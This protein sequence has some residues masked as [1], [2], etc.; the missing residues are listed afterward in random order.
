MKVHTVGELLHWSYANLAMAHAAVT[1]GSPR[2]G[3]RHFAIRSRL[4]AGLRNDSLQI[5]LLAEDERLKM[6]LPQACCYCGSTEKLAADHLIP[7]K[8]GGPDRGDNLVW[9]CRACNS[10]K[11]AS[12]ALEWYARRGEFPPLLVLRRYLKLALELCTASGVLQHPIASSPSLPVTL[13]AI[14]IS[15]PRPSE[16]RLWVAPIAS[17]PLTRS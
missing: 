6:V 1:D 15:F 14:P 5:G 10:S 12:D 2:F 4:Y 11:G 7:R 13:S 9:A 3:A 17:Q 8:R 16:L